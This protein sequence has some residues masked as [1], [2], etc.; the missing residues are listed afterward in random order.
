MSILNRKTSVIIIVLLALVMSGC[1][2]RSQQEPKA[3]EDTTD[4]SV[5]Y[6]QAAE[7][8]AVELTSVAPPVV[9]PT[10]E[11][12][13]MPEAPS[14]TMEV[15]PPTSTPLPTATSIPTDTPLPTNT[16][17][18]TE[19]PPPTAT[20]TA[21]APPPPP[22]PSFVQAYYDSFAGGFWPTR[23][24]DQVVF[25]YTN[26]GYQVQNNVVWDMVYATRSQLELQFSD[27]RIEVRGSRVQGA[28]NGYYGVT[29]RFSDGQHYYAL[30]VG[31]DGWYGIGRKIANVLVWLAE[32]KNTAAVRTGSAANMI[33]AD[34]LGDRLT[35]WANDNKLAEVQ[36]DT[37][38]AGSFGVVVGTREKSGYE[39][40]FDD[41]YV[42]TPTG[43]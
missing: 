29:C 43:Q 37:Y 35:L 13:A 25:R 41:Y 17:P 16:L 30:V 1:L 42:F 5:M 6:T 33:R 34:C 38:S 15:L 40:L 28:I 7:T 12:A 10:Q 9:E 31:S 20:W 36:D 4:E 21:T 14:P 11:S 24:N 22:E 27:L 3:P 26:G 2:S 18:P 19:P 23:S 39:A 32:G 8:I